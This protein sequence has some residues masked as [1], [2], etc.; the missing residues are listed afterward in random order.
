MF[1]AGKIWGETELIL[2]N[3]ALEF[4][5]I[6][7]KK[8]GVEMSLEEVYQFEVVDSNQPLETQGSTEDGRTQEAR[9][10]TERVK[11]VAPRLKRKI[12]DYWS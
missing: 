12:E 4:H 6:D 2:A 9:L 10:Y 8:G 1:K 3:N 5:R 7:Y 11:Q